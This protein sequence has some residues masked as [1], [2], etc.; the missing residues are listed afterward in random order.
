M[1]TEVIVVEM[2]RERLSRRLEISFLYTVGIDNAA[3][4]VVDNL[5]TSFK[6]RKP[7][8]TAKRE[9]RDLR[10][11]AVFTLRRNAD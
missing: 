10:S 1:L 7:K 3:G 6:L 2:F 9:L 5:N 11:G 4:G 8:P